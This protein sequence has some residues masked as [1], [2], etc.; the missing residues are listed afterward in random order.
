[1]EKYIADFIKNLP[2][3]QE[4]TLEADSEAVLKAIEAQHG[5]FVEWAKGIYSFSHLTFQE[6]FAAKYI[7]SK[8]DPN[9]LY[10]LM[11]CYLTDYKWREVFLL[12]TGMLPQ[13]DDFLLRMKVEADK[14]LRNKHSIVIMRNATRI[15]YKNTRAK[16]NPWVERCLIVGILFALISDDSIRISSS[17]NDPEDIAI[18]REHEIACTKGLDIVCDLLLALDP[19][20]AE[21]FDPFRRDPVRFYSYTK[22]HRDLFKLTADT[23]EDLFH[24]TDFIRSFSV[25][26]VANKLLIDCLNSDC[27]IRKETRGKILDEI[28]TAK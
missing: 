9:Y 13:A 6:Y 15:V 5:I 22:T 11:D 10:T 26:L 16:Y 27:Y 14:L 24:D 1:M 25:Y 12:V 3:T 23:A 8:Q 2:E 7:V 21:D 28:F 18:Y 17:S 4:K 19:A 20:L